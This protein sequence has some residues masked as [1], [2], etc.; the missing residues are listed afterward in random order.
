MQVKDSKT[1]TTTR[2]QLVER[3]QAAFKRSV[4]P[5]LSRVLLEQS[6]AYQLQVK[7]RGAVGNRVRGALLA[8]S[9][10]EGFVPT[11]LPAP[12]AKLIRE[13]HG[14]VHVVEVCEGGFQYEGRWYRSLTA[15]AEEIT[16]SHWSGPRF[17][18][19]RKP[20]P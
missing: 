4:P 17:F 20:A 15:I 14:I 18:G 7:G 6:L 11:R 16:G 12:G 3:W 8:A 10:S 2:C 13:W 9:R 19:L 1:T 5:R